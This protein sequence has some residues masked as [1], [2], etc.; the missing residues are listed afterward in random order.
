[1]L[2]TT[3]P[4]EADRWYMEHYADSLRPSFTKVF[5]SVYPAPDTTVDKLGDLSVFA[6][7]EPYLHLGWGFRA[8]SSQ[9][10]I[11]WREDVGDWG[12]GIN[13]FV[14][15]RRPG[16]VRL[17]PGPFG[18]EGWVRVVEY[19]QPN[20]FA[21]SV[22]SVVDNLLILDDVHATRAGTASTE[23]VSGSVL[24][25]TIE[26]GWVHFRLEIPSD[27]PC[28]DEVAADPPMVRYVAPVSHFVTSEGRPKFWLA[29]PKGC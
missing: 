27:M 2:G 22:Y 12:Y 26:A 6:N 10:E 7:W 25:E 24:I 1:M 14:L 18:N 13:E 15:D 28:G 11:V 9:T 16:W 20:G 19:D 23:S 3:V 21:G 5:A 4:I 29:Y 8:D 17:P